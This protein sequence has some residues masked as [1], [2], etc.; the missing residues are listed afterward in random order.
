M[1]KALVTC[2]ILALALF[3]LGAADTAPKG[4]HQL[5]WEQYR[6]RGEPYVF[7]KPLPA[8]I[9][10][11][12]KPHATE[13]GLSHTV[14]GYLPYWERNSA[15]QYFDYDV[16]SHI[17]LFDFSVAT[18]GSISAYPP[19]WPG[20]WE[21]TMNTA[22]ANGV[23]LIM[24]VVEFD[25]DDIHA[26]I[27]SSTASQHFYEEVESVINSYNLDGVN[28]DFEGLYTSDRGSVIN[29]FMRGLRD[30][31]HTHVGTEQEVSFAGPP[32][33]WSSWD[34]PGLTDACDY[35][36]IM[37]YNYWWSGSATTGPCA[38]IT[39]STY[40]LVHTLEN[41]T[42]GYGD[43]DRSKLILGLPYYGLYWEVS[44]SERNTAGAST[45]SS[46]RS[47]FYAGARDKYTAWGTFW[48]TQYEDSWTSYESEGKWYQVWCSNAQAMDAK[49]ELV[50]SYDLKGTGMWALGYDDEH[51]ELWNIL[52]ENFYTEPLPQFYTVAGYVRF[53]AAGVPGVSIADT[54]TDSSGYFER[55]YAA[56][57]SLTLA[58]QKADWEFS[59][60]EI[61]LPLLHRDTLLYFEGIPED[62]LLAPFPNPGQEYVHISWLLG[63]PAD[64]RIDAYDI[65]GRRAAELLHSP[66]AAG[67]QQLT[68]HCGNLPAGLYIV[69]LRVNGVPAASQKFILVK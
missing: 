65:R 42:R 16:L 27:N 22:H 1:R 15:P 12:R 14:F 35:V 10:P 53:N 40:N 68:W 28:I 21:N 69:T 41:T 5:E 57:T 61:S 43:C 26:L 13:D 62:R 52:R 11:L 33:N 4:I 29:N 45:L 64:V 2:F 38:P 39:G 34:L 54:L 31:L 59:P 63:A 51:P 9:I 55:R 20:D 6:E 44:E 48:S 49:E 56:G 32:V 67:E 37:G 47:I 18:D 7:E 50:L 46:G 36:F 23:K 19:G 17:A 3:P 8:D 58:P 25:N 30:Y 24:C 66:Q 60:A